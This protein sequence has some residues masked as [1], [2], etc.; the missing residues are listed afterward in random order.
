MRDYQ[1]RGLN[2]LIQLQHNGINGILADEMVKNI[3]LIVVSFLNQIYFKGSRKNIA[4]DISAWLCQTLQTPKWPLPD[5]CAEINI[6]KLG[7]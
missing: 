7:E 5:Y 4:N 2:W 6:T 1:V 3:C